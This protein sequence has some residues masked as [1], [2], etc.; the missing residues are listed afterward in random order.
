MLLALALTAFAD[1]D[2]IAATPTEADVACAPLTLT[3]SIP[4][5]NQVDVP[6]DVSPT[7]IFQ[8]NCGG[9][10]D[11]TFDIHD[12]EGTI[13]F[14]Q[15]WTWDDSVT[16][17]VTINPD[18]DLPSN[19][20]L[21]LRATPSTDGGEWGELVEIPF[22]TGESHVVPLSGAPTVEI[23]SAVWF[24]NTQLV[25]VFAD[26]VP[27]DDPNHLSLLHVQSNG[28]DFVTPAAPMSD[29]AFS[30]FE[31][32]A[33]DEVCVTVT[34]ID[35][36]GAASEAVKACENPTHRLSGG[37]GC[38]GASRTTPVSAFLLLGAVGL[39]RRRKG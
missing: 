39:F 9:A 31:A 24:R 10:H 11:W 27:I 33:P 37:G 20:D 13:L 29:Q 21:V 6:V 2:G 8:G 5:A 32:E 16:A 30:W 35:G 22:S 4:A 34:Q 12:A 7:L 25:E 38:F 14:S 1:D 36:S 3:R 15:T 23:T 19:A 17:L 26:I 18:G 28:G